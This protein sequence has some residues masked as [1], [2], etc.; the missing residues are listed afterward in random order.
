MIG[1]LVLT[2][3]KL[4]EG[5]NDALR[6]IVGEVGSLDFLGL[7]PGEDLDAYAAR[8]KEKAEAIMSDLGVLV[9]TDI[10]GGTPF[11]QATKLLSE[12]KL[13][14]VTGVNLGMLLSAHLNRDSANDI[15]ELAETAIEEGKDSMMLL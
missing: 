7:T 3:G 9:L 11:N 4:A 8:V 6:M 14:I 1:I 10:V 13:C 12:L 2:H 5:L 15:R